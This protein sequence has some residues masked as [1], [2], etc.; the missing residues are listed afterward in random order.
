MAH[1]CLV[2]FFT[3]LNSCNQSTILI[4]HVK[5]TLVRNVKGVMVGVRTFG[6]LHT[7]VQRSDPDAC[8]LPGLIPV[9]V[10]CAKC[11]LRDFWKP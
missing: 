1:L 8:K 4:R 9:R 5:I 11:Y 2:C 6:G 10:T 3:R 7:G